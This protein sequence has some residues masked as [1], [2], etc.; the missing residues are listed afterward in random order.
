MQ[1]R[2][3]A[4]LVLAAMICVSP[5]T[6]RAAGPQAA[7]PAVAPDASA[8]HQATLTQVPASRVTTRG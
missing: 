4:I 3:F 2:V 6:P 8:V 1:G 7:V 5:S